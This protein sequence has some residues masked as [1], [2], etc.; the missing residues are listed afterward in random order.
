MK[1]K[2][3]IQHHSIGG[4]VC[5]GALLLMGSSALAQNM[6]VGSFGNEDIVE[7]PT[8]GP[9]S[10]FASGITLPDGIAFDSSG[11]FFEA[12]QDAGNIYEYTY[13][14]GTFSST[15][16]TFATGLSQP[17]GI[18]FNGAGLLFAES[19]NGNI[20]D[21]TSSGMRNTFATGVSSPG[22]LA[23]DTAGN[24]Y[25]ASAPNNEI[26]KFTPGDVESIFT[27]NVAYPSGMVF[28]SAGDLLVG[29]GNGAGTIE[30]VTP[31]GVVTTYATGL[32][33]P[34]G[35]AFDTNGDLFVADQGLGMENGDVTEFTAGGSRILFNS[36]I[37]K[38]VSVA[39]QGEALPV[40]EPSTYGLFATGASTLLF[41]RRRKK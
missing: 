29:N 9:S 38:P 36:T 13:S 35:M 33:Q 16:T 34:T 19:A 37:S 17:A 31:G 27:A 15:R 23:F 14:G 40:P 8:S 39:F 26:L 5:A 3:I 4:A 32:N 12:D 1:T 10:V 22:A 30:Q 24:L 18:A 7:F 11:D 41:L 25:V 28:N 20:Y 2:T 6:F 21:Y